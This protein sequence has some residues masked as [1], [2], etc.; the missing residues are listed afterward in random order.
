MTVLLILYEIFD[1]EPIFG[2]ISDQSVKV[3]V[4][5]TV[6]RLIG[7]AIFTVILLYLGFKVMD[8]FRKPFWRSVV[9]SLPA[10]LVVVN[11]LPIYPLASGLAKVD[12]PVWKILLLAAE[13]FAIGFF[14]E[15]CFRGVIFLG[16]LEKIRAKKSGQLISILLTSAVFGAVHLINLVEGSSPASVLMQIGYSFLIGSMC[17]VVLIKT[18]NIW[19]CVLL[20]AAFDL[21]GALVPTCGSGIIW[22]PLTVTL[23]VLIAVFATVYFVIAFI[24]IKKEEC[25]RLYQG[26]RTY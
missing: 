17:S 25:D 6:T 4:D 14:E 3:L 11:N 10:V 1:L 20:H 13:C 16:F 8:P 7:G 24:H 22:E 2:E 21:C 18:A 12:A 26:D 23:T 15:L 19:L 5:M 9:F